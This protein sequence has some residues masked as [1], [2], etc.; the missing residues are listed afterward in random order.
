MLSR[1]FLLLEFFFSSYPG[2]LVFLYKFLAISFLVSVKN[3]LEFDKNCVES[4]DCFW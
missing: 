2:S 4:V 1:V 3:V